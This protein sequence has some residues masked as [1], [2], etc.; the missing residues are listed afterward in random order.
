LRRCV[1]DQSL[2]AI[3]NTHGSKQETVDAEVERV[4]AEDVNETKDAI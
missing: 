3:G 1:R 2:T 4:A